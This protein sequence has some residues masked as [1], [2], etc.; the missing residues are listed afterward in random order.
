MRLAFA[1][2][3]LCVAGPLAAG[4]R[5]TIDLNG[6]WQFRTDPQSAGDQQEWHSGP[7]S[8]DR[9]IQV[10]GA[11]QAQG[12]GERRGIL[13]NHYSGPAWYRRQVSIPASWKG[14]AVHLRVGGALRRT[15]V[16]VNGRKLGEHDGFSS[17]FSF[18]IGDALRAGAENTLAFRVVNPGATIDDAPHAQKGN[19]PT[20]MMN[21]IGNWGGIFGQV[22]L[23]ATERTW[24]DEV[25]I[26]PRIATGAAVIR[27]A[28]RSKDSGRVGAGL[29]LEVQAGGA[30]A[31]APV[32]A[33]GSTEVVVTIP[34]ARLWSPETPHLY[35]AVVRLLD[36]PRELDRLDER[37]GMREI[38]TRGRV[39]LLNGKPLYLR[40]YGDDNVEV[41]TGVPPAS[42]QVHLDRLKLARSFGFNAVRFHSMTPVQEY[43]EAAD[44][45]GLLIMAELPAAYTMYFLPH[46][47]FLRAELEGV[48]RSYR[49]RPSF[50]SLAFGNEFNLN[51]L[52]TEAEK[53]EFQA[54]VDEFY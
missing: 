47:E 6:A 21:Y 52:K 7:M 49:N 42:R 2:C 50:L 35:T 40:G 16:Y 48:L 30:T 3:L 14:K 11:W 1:L 5:P 28:L 46:K 31:T 27:V 9:T 15:A 8:F 23:E 34:N 17:P 32:N 44:E 51:W 13:R 10:P 37:F 36:G 12:I 45:V 43:F 41:L 4:P 20:G 54:A 33:G 24:I 22:E 29:R 26:V 19:E 39:L 38:T 53:K 25:A 18:E